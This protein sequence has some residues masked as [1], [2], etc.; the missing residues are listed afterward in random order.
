MKIIKARSPFSVIVEYANSIEQKVE[1]FINEGLKYTFSSKT[2]TVFNVSNE[3]LEYIQ[4]I[5]PVTDGGIEIEPANMYCRVTIVGYYRLVDQSFVE[6]YSNNYIAV[7]AYVEYG[8]GLQNT[9]TVT[10]ELNYYI[11]SK[12]YENQNIPLANYAQGT[13]FRFPYIDILFDPTN[14][15]LYQI[16][17]YS[18]SY[19]ID[20]NQDDGAELM[21][22]IPLLKSGSS[23]NESLSYGFSIIQLQTDT[24][25]FVRGIN[26]ICEQKYTPMLLSFIGKFGGWEHIYCFK[27]NEVNIETKDTEYKTSQVYADFNPEIGQRQNYNLNGT[28]KIKLNTGFVD[29]SITPLIE[30]LFLSQTVT[31]DGLPMMLKS[32]SSELKQLLKSNINYTF[33]LEYNFNLIND[34]I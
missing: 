16:G 2:N 18:I 15:N 21:F 4:N 10:T 28:K 26:I 25:F 6:L 31:L 17:Y 22:R 27:A 9:N 1:L 13:D 33:E 20:I 30:Q 12:G 34:F 19:S 32:K 3:I 5:M 23:I 11:A 8:E 24:R 7:N 14:Y 29:E